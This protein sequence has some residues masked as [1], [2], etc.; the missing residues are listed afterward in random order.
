MMTERLRAAFD[1]ESA[2]LAGERRYGPHAETLDEVSVRLERR[3]TSDELV[4][5]L[6]AWHRR[7]PAYDNATDWA[8]QAC[9]I[10]L[11]Q[12]EIRRRT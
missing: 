3:I 4:D 10:L 12:F 5:A 8:R 7:A 11:A 1:E 2:R 6:A 9:S